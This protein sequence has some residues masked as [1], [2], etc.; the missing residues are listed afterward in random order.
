MNL[1]SPL[2]C[3]LLLIAIAAVLLTIAAAWAFRRG[4]RHGIRGY[5][6]KAIDA[7]NQGFYYGR[8]SERGEAE[9]E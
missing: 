1:Q 5:E 4:Y 9:R 2:E 6:E 7:F 8:K 3:W